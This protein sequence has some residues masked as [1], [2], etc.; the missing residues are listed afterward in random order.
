MQLHLPEKSSSC[1]TERK[2]G[3][4]CALCSD[5]LAQSASGALEGKSEGRCP[6][7]ARGSCPYSIAAVFSAFYFLHVPGCSPAPVQ[8]VGLVTAQ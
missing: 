2:Y 1:L 7:L 8:R 6:C 3:A 4:V 5:F